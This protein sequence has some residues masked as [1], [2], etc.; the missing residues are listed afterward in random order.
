MKSSDGFPQVEI[1]IEPFQT[2][3]SPTRNLQVVCFVGVPD[4]RILNLMLRARA[5]LSATRLNQPTGV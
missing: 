3:V 5:V 1:L 2:H 4:V